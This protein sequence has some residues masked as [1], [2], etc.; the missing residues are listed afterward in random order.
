MRIYM[1]KSIPSKFPKYK[2]SIF[3]ENITYFQKYLFITCLLY[4]SINIKETLK[5][6]N[7]GQLLSMNWLLNQLLKTY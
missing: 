1:K 6:Y 2:I 3:E 4:T 7:Q 5:G